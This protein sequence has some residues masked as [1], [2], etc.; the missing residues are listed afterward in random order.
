MKEVAM[1]LRR[2]IW[3]LLT[4][5]LLTAPALAQSTAGSAAV[6]TAPNKICPLPIGSPVPQINLQTLAAEPFDL[7]ARLKSK[8]TILIYFRGGW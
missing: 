7:H 3:I 4:F 5:C 8:P 2:T 6:P 1:N